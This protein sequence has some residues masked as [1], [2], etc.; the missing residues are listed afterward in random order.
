MSWIT[1]GMFSMGNMNPDSS[2]DG[3]ITKKLTII[4]CC[5]V[6]EIVEISSPSQAGQ[7]EGRG[8]HEEQRTRPGGTRNRTGNGRH[9]RQVNEADQGGMVC[10]ASL[11]V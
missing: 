10:R 3:S 8:E 5:C 2:S 1:R 4:A 9:E 11:A 7:Q 6:R